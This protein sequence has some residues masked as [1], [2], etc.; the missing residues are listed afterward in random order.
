MPG[1]AQ[2]VTPIVR[3]FVA[4]LVTTAVLFLA[5]PASA[6]ILP[7]DAPGVSATVS[8]N[9]WWSFGGSTWEHDIFGLGIAGS[10]L[11]WKDVESPVVMATGDFAW[12][13]LVLSAGVGWGQ[14][15]DGTLVDED[16]AFGSTFSRTESDVRDSNVFMVNADVGLRP[17]RWRDSQAR[18]G[19]IDVLVG[20]Q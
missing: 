8:T 1:R 12:R 7:V 17:L 13:F 3:A 10:K 20:Y 14:V 19:F 11:D 5:V 18:L 15:I 16:F 9:A 2:A 6:Q 4:T